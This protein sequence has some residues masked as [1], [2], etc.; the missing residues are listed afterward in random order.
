MEEIVHLTLGTMMDR[1]AAA[2]WSRCIGLLRV[3]RPSFM[4]VS[5]KRKTHKSVDK[6]KQTSF[7][8][9]SDFVSGT[10]DY[11]GTGNGIECTD[12]DIGRVVCCSQNDLCYRSL[13]YILM[14]SVSN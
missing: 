4:D 14:T 10:D 9:F 11:K 5:R 6:R 13:W 2:L 7:W 3:A 8:G 1:S 12:E